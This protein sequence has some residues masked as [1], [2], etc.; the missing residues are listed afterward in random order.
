M[1]IIYKK[2]NGQATDL[3]FRDMDYKLA[4][5]EILYGEGDTLP[6]IDTLHDKVYTDSVTAKAGLETKIQA[7]IRAMAVKSLQAKGELPADFKG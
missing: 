3:S 2:T 6:D 5:G 7:E 4:E 1:K